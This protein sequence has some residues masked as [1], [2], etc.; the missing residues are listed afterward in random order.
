MNP[1]DEEQKRR[2]REALGKKS[3]QLFKILN[4]NHPNLVFMAKQRKQRQQLN[5]RNAATLQEVG[6]LVN[7]Y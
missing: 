5:R 2:I 4:P 1:D 7:N 6:D 3:Y